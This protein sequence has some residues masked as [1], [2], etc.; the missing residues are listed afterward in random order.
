[1]SEKVYGVS[2]DWAKRAWIDEARYEEMY[3]RSIK[4]PDGFWGDEGKR[5]DWFKPYTKVQRHL[6]RYAPRR[7]QMVRGRRHQRRSQLHRSAPRQAR[8]P[9]R[10][11]LGRRRSPAASKHITYGELHEQV[12]RFANVLEGA[13]R[14]EGRPRH[15]L[16]CR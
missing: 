11:H 7:D 4:D 5:I 12:C 9:D 16:P 15:D 2:A 6:V 14:Q 13:G 10:D 1:M 8:R 3:Q